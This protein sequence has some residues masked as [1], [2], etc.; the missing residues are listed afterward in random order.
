MG[1]TLVLEVH[2]T[3]VYNLCRYIKYSNLS[4]SLGFRVYFHDTCPCCTNLVACELHTQPYG[5]K[6]IQYQI[7]SCKH[8]QDSCK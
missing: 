2:N 5:P 7:C 6:I 4:I 3:I 8:D 1:L